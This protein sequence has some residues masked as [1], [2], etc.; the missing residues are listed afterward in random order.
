[1][2]ESTGAWPVIA[3]YAALDADGGVTHLSFV[4]GDHATKFAVPLPRGNTPLWAMWNT[5]H[6]VMTKGGSGSIN[7]GILVRP[8]PGRLP[9]CL[10]LTRGYRPMP[11]K[12]PSDPVALEAI[13]AAVVMAVRLATG[14]SEP[15][16]A[17]DVL[18]QRVA[19]AAE[20]RS[21]ARDAGT[22]RRSTK[23]AAKTTQ[24]KKV[25]PSAR[26]AKAP[27]AVGKKAHRGA[28]GER[29]PDIG[30]GIRLTQD[31]DAESRTVWA[32]RSGKSFHRRDCHLVEGRDGAV[33]IPIATA[34]QRNLER[35]M[36][37]APT[38]R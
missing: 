10:E 30:T 2:I 4:P 28:T 16:K 34:R 8:D 5:V 24:R 18:R 3:L 29:L 35:C 9:T 12:L 25:K 19:A 33:R 7:A 15:L 26:S 1:M 22:M 37:C 31:P 23:A 21:R 11:I 6:R 27:P 38:V 14:A 36:H 32:F 13:R 17:A 20:Q